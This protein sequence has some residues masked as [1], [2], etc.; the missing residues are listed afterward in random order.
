MAI[1]N[2]SKLAGGLA[3]D[4]S[5]DLHP[6]GTGFPP[7]LSSRAIPQHLCNRHGARGVKGEDEHDDNNPEQK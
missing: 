7:L 3:E 4:A 6:T 1:P 5:P 2:E